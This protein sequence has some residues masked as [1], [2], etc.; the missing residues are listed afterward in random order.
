M[1]A[2][3]PTLDYTSLAAGAVAP[4][5]FDYE[6]QSERTRSLRRRFLWF[7]GINVLLQV[8]F[9]LA[10]AGDIRNAP[11]L[12]RFLNVLSSVLMIGAYVAAF[13][14]VLRW[15]PALATLLKLGLYITAILPCLEMIF[16]RVDFSL[17]G[18]GWDEVFGPKK[19]PPGMMWA[20]FSPMWLFLVFTLACAFIRWT[21]REALRPA[22]VLVLANA[23][24]IVL[25]I[26]FTLKS[27]N[28]R[29]AAIISLALG[30]FAVLPGLLIC[31]WRF[32]RFRKNFRIRFE[33]SGYRNLQNEL[34]GARRVHE[35]SLPRHDLF[36][37]GPVRLAYV[38]EPMRQIGGDILYVHPPDD[39]KAAVVSVVLV[40]VNGHGIS[41]A[42]MA[43]R[44][45]GEVQRLFAENPHAPPTEVLCALNRYVRLTMSRS[46]I[47]ATA[48][49]LRIDSVQNTLEYAN[50]G[51][52]P[53]FVRRAGG[54]MVRL[55]PQTYLLGVVDGEEY[56]PPA[57]RVEFHAGDAVFAYTDGASEAADA[58]GRMIGIDGL[59]ERLA[60]LDSTA[61][62]WPGQLLH[63]IVAHRRAPA[64]DDTLLV[65]IYRA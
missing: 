30:T 65:A 51:H 32:S 28:D 52:P 59:R 49:C 55:E 3:K 21:L 41:A 39:S 11:P 38:Y 7:C 22:A 43:N 31:W 40:D 10:F 37:T 27:T 53:A 60:Q 50:G 29:I 19:L 33:M 15:R 23:A 4:S 9:T 63:Q 1:T 34:A 64:A 8:Y 35:S 5:E 46:A 57:Q 17:N 58:E 36:S 45:T 56:C 26:A 54:E 20:F 2:A 16:T 42:L 14:Y 47:F 24:V 48:L 6:L 13:V 61:G 12:A 18:S 25:D 44:V 62:R